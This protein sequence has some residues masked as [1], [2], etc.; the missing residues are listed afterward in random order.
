MPFHFNLC[1][2]LETAHYISKHTVTL[3]INSSTCMMKVGCDSLIAINSCKCCLNVII[4]YLGTVC[5]SSAL[6]T[7]PGPKPQRHTQ[8]WWWFSVPK[9]LLISPLFSSS[10]FLCVCGGG[11]GVSAVS[12]NPSSLINPR[13]VENAEEPLRQTGCHNRKPHLKHKTWGVCFTARSE[14]VTDTL[15]QHGLVNLHSGSNWNKEKRNT[16]GLLTFN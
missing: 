5:Y 6:K 12:L 11:W 8:I 7:Q 16:S 9:K 3:S 14:S 15:Q 2:E 10:F 13:A 1:H 4:S